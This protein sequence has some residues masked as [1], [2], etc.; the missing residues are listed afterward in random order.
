M[1]ETV[2]IKLEVDGGQS[3][4]KIKKLEEQ[5][6]E[7]ETSFNDLEEA[8]KSQSQSLQEN[9][10]KSAQSLDKIAKQNTT[11]GEDTSKVAEGMTNGYTAFLGVSTLVGTDQEQ[12]IKTFVKLQ[13]V[14]Q[15]LNAV[16]KFSNDLKKESAFRQSASNLATKIGVGL[17]KA[18]AFAVGTGSKAMKIFRLALI[19]TGIGAL[20]VG[21]G[22][23]I[24]KWDDWKESIM[25]FINFALAPVIWGLQALG[26]IES[27]LEKQRQKNAE[28][29]ISRYD[30]EIRNLNAK[31]KAEEGRLKQEIALAQARGENTDKLQEKLLKSQI[32]NT[33]D[34]VEQ[35]RKKYVDMKKLGD[36][37]TQ[38][39]LDEQNVLREKLRQQAKDEERALQLE[40]VKQEEAK[41]EQRRKYAE[42]RRNEQKA[43]NDKLLALQRSLED[44]IIEMEKDADVK[45]LAKLEVSQQRERDAL[46]KKYGEQSK[47]VKLLEEKQ[48]NEMAMLIDDIE[49]KAKE[50]NDEKIRTEAQELADLK[51]EIADA[52]V[53]TLE[54]QRQKEFEDLDTYYT[55]L[56]DKARANK[57]D[58]LNLEETFLAKQKELKDKN[59]KED[60]ERSNQETEKA[61][62]NIKAQQGARDELINSISGGLT[63]L[64][65]LMKDNE[66]KQKASALVQIATDTALAIS[67]LVAQSQQ[68][69]LNGVT[70]GVA[71][72]V[73]FASGIISIMGNMAK[74]KQLL[75]GGSGVT[76]PSTSV[77]A[78]PTNL[79]STTIGANNGQTGG[80]SGFGGP[81]TQ[82]NNGG[83]V[84][85]VES[86]LEAMQD[87]RQ[88][89]QRIATI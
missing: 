18:Y 70:M 39:Q 69:A 21:I 20:A 23:I 16:Q 15:T 87:R 50:K 60:E 13:T 57:Q 48:A 85:L 64:T 88:T 51:K 31:A 26:I 22:L 28:N 68:N 78:P 62:A 37:Y 56:I 81:T 65:S 34:L 47:L 8:E 43:E 5:V 33:K 45:A 7:L 17:Q 79:T 32:K 46:V 30:K 40:R 3:V 6:N 53:N 74:A 63:G 19:S 38:E 86:E 84:V 80:G 11:I 29:N 36:K 41:K 73:Q 72:A 61:I 44:S 82:N 83:R 55:D 77:G 75:S 89:T 66:K 1:A 58:T 49:A 25:K 67:S 14:Q 10:D 12:L 42:Q 54:E 4:D 2:A 59:A 24:A 52:E 71:G 27:D 76:A 9:A 35:E